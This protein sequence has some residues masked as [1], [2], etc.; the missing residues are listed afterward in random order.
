M[1]PERVKSITFCFP[2][3]D[4]AAEGEMLPSKYW[5]SPSVDVDSI[6]ERPSGSAKIAGL[7]SN[8]DGEGAFV[9][10]EAFMQRDSLWR[11]QLDYHDS[12]KMMFI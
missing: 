3:N 11:L 9:P 2:R 1:K 8:A 10:S 4:T 12:R 6:Q 5:L 7:F